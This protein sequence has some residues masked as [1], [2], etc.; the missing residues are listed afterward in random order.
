MLLWKSFSM[1]RAATA[2]ISI[3]VEIVDITLL[4]I[5]KARLLRKLINQSFTGIVNMS[6]EKKFRSSIWTSLL[7]QQC[8]ELLRRV[9][10]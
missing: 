5:S 8:N 1:R 4:V 9:Q 3:S 2:V 7:R 10:I 6:K